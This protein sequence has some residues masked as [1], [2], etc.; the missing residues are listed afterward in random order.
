[1]LDTTFTVEHTQDE[2]GEDRYFVADSN[3]DWIGEPYPSYDLASEKARWHSRKAQAV[4]VEVFLNHFPV[5]TEFKLGAGAGRAYAGTYR[6]NAESTWD[7]VSAPEK[8]LVINMAAAHL[9]FCVGEDI[10]RKAIDQ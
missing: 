5:G 2:F 7:Q 4:N 1:M 10:I 9:G 6:K 3:G 8:P